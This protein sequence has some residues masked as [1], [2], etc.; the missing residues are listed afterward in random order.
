MVAQILQTEPGQDDARLL[1]LSERDNVLVARQQIEAGEQMLVGGR[2]Y[3]LTRPVLLGHKV[4]RYAI[5]EG[6]KVIKYG[7]AIGS[8]FRPILPGEHVH[9]HNLKSDYT[10]THVIK[11]SEPS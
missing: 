1:L 8:A 2:A 9:L 4:A 11:G 6:A 10:K 3:V 7:V 5:S